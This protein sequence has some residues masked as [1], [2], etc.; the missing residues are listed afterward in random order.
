M[1]FSNV[2][3]SIKLN[4]LQYLLLFIFGCLS[5]KSSLHA[6]S[7]QEQSVAPDANGSIAWCN[8]VLSSNAHRPVY[9]P[10]VSVKTRHAGKG[11]ATSLPKVDE[12]E[13]NQLNECIHEHFEMMTEDTILSPVVSTLSQR[14]TRSM[15]LE[16]SRAGRP[17]V[18]HTCQDCC[19]DVF[20]PGGANPRGS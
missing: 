17:S 5:S 3:T 16:G 1:Q 11:S 18:E 10:Q 4:R 20:H 13:K 8:S 6:Y 14:K 7:S 19:W 15:L 12:T 2:C 9:F